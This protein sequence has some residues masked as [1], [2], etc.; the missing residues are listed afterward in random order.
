MSCFGG[1]EVESEEEKAEVAPRP[2]GLLGLMPTQASKRA[3]VAICR[4]QSHRVSCNSIMRA[5]LQWFAGVPNL[6]PTCKAF[7]SL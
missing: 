7:I 5:L 6:W 4:R 3:L 2:V 1:F